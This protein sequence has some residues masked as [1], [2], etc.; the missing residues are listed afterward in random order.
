MADYIRLTCDA[1]KRLTLQNFNGLIGAGLIPEEL[2]YETRVFNFNKSLKKYCKIGDYYVMPEPFMKFY[3]Q[4]FNTD[5]LTIIDNYPAIK[6]TSWDKIYKNTM[7]KVRDWLKAHH[8]ETLAKYN[9]MLFMED[10]NKYCKGN[11][12]AWEMES[13]SFYHSEHELA[14]VNRIKY[15]ISNFSELPAVPE[16]EY[17][18]KRAGKDIP[19]FKLTRIVGTVIGKNKTKS[20]ISLLTTDGVVSV[21]FRPEYF[22]MFDKQL[23]EKQEDGTKKIVEK[24]W[25][26]KGSKLML[27]GFRRDDQFVPKTYA[28]TATHTLYKIDEVLENGDLEL[29]SER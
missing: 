18:F 8:D 20:M 27:T 4:F 17:Y 9:D 25:F 23:S 29:R 3:E 16:V 22:A 13:L 1:K 7:D 21:K 12:S 10:W 11:V 19:I 24:S 14:H 28:N 26:N 15:G 2:I 5:I 6:Q